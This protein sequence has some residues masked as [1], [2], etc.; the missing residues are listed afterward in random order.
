MY[1]K[2]NPTVAKTIIF[3]LLTSV[4]SI[5]EAEAPTVPSEPPYIV[6]SDNLDEPNGFGFCIDTYSR[7]KT[8]LL[9]THTCKP[10]KK[11]RPRDYRDNDTRF[12]YDAET[13]KIASYAFSGFC[14]QALIANEITVFA[15]L[16]C[17]DHPR[18]KFVYKSGDQTLRLYEDQS[19]CISVSEKTQVA[20]PW[21]KRPLKLTS[22]EETMPQL[23][24][25]NVVK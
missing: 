24:T 14:M 25:W 5:V 11:E 16:E 18:Q 1:L 15:L 9:Q 7:G 22:C 6:L 4:V 13:G 2:L 21:V 20:G 17:N 23:K 8:D 12:F 3:F 19:R 10:K